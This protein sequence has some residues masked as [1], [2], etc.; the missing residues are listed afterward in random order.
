[1]EGVSNLRPVCVALCD[2]GRSL[3][4]FLRVAGGAGAGNA[5]ADGPI[6]LP[7][8]MVHCPAALLV[9]ASPRS[10][11]LGGAE[12]GRVTPA[13]GGEALATAGRCA[14][15]DTVRLN[16]G[17]RPRPR[18]LARQASLSG[19]SSANTTRRAASGGRGVRTVAVPIS[20]SVAFSGFT[21]TAP[22]LAV[23]AEASRPGGDGLSLA[24][25]TAPPK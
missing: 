22:P 4:S 17:R 16:I 25:F 21:S 1:M 3:A 11:G 20:E 24:Q 15:A 6:A 23:H 13:S 8:R 10:H 2:K 7:S 12:T 5:E 9:A 18:R 14:K 19:P